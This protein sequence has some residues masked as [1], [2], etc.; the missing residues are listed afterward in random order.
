MYLHVCIKWNLSITDTLGVAL[1]KWF[2]VRRFSLF[3]G[4]F[5]C[6]AIHLV[7][8]KQSVI[9]R[10]SLFHYIYF[11]SLLLDVPWYMQDHIYVCL[12]IRYMNVHTYLIEF[13]L[14]FSSSM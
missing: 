5:T 13:Q 11:R 4:Y 2:V 12:G 6:I 3:R 9:E 8:L 1:K 14:H 10:F 7:P